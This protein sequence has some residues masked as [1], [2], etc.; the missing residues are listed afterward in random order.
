[1]LYVFVRWIRFKNRADPIADQ[2]ILSLKLNSSNWR[3][4]F[5][6]PTPSP[7]PIPFHETSLSVA[8]TQLV[9]SPSPLPPPISS[10][11]L[12]FFSDAFTLLFL[13]HT[14]ICS[15]PLSD[16][17]EAAHLSCRFAASPPAHFVISFRFK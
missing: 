9:F 16:T 1:M 7:S 6:F 15:P 13:A 11:D 17:G 5:I 2:K 4:P 3:C 10:C 12:V 8:S 14:K